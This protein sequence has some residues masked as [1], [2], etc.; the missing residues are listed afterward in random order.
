M[1]RRLSDAYST[2]SFSRRLKTLRYLRSA[3]IMASSPVEIIQYLVDTRELWVAATRTSDL[4]TEASRALA[5]L[6]PDERARVLKYYFIAD[7]KMALASHLL[8]HWVVS[9]YCGVPWWET[10]LSA[11]KNGK[12]ISKDSAG[13]QPVVFNVSHQA[14]LVALVAAHGYDATNGGDSSKVNIGVDI[15]LLT[16]MPMSSDGQKPRI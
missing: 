6:T 4:E 13:R 14:G 11:D 10:K 8:K 16:C 3:T 5:L 2:E 7:A 12:P 1:A 15:V 9:K